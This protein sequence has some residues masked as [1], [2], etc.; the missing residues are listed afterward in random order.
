MS[1]ISY[2]SRDGAHY[3]SF[4]FVANGD[5]IDIEVVSMPN[6]NGQDPDPQF[7]HLYPSGKICFVPGKAPTDTTR[8]QEMAAEWAEYICEYRKTGVPQC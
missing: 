8:A 3:F 2:R 1:N 6:L 4:R 7:T 5:V